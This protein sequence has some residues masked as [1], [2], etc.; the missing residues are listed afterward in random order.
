MTTYKGNSGVVRQST[1]SIAELTGFTVTETMGTTEDTA[2]GDTARSFLA[3]GL[4]AWSASVEG[5]YYP[6]DTN[7]QATIVAGAELNWSF[8]F[9]GTGTGTQKFSGAGIITQLQVGQL[10]NGQPIPFSAQIQGNGA[11]TRGTN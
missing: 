2:L 10:Q 9:I 6:G 5:H 8:N 1:Y 7:G 11:L 3:D 4:Q